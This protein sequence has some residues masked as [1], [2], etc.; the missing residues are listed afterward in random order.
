MTFLE[1]F[2]LLRHHRK[3]YE[4]RHPMWEQNRTVKAVVWI[5][6]AMV[7]IYLIFIGISLALAA[8]NIDDVTA[9]EL[10]F[11]IMPF[12]LTLD[13]LLRFTAQQTPTQMV[14][15]Y[16]LLPLPRKTCTDTFI[17]NSLL[18]TGNLIWMAMFVPYALVSVVF[19]YGVSTTLLFLLAC[20]IC[21]LLNSQWYLL[22]RTLINI[23]MW[24][25]L[26]P[27][28]V[29]AA[30]YSPLFIM[31]ADKGILAFIDFFAS[32]GDRLSNGNVLA[33][34][35]LLLMITAAVLINR[36]VQYRCI[37]NELNHKEQTR[38]HSISRMSYFNRYGTTGEFLK[39]EAKSIMRN[40]NVKKT[41]IFANALVLFISLLVALSDIYD[42]PF[43]NEFWCV[44]NF[45]IYG[46]MLL[47]KTMCYEG[48]Y[49]EC[50]MTHRN[51]IPSL[52]SAKYLFCTAM[53]LVPFVLTL[54]T[55]IAGKWTLLQVASVMVFAGG[56]INSGLL[57]L[58]IYNKQTMPLNTRF[59]GKG[60]MESNW[61]QVIAQM[62]IMFVPV[63]FIF[64]C[65]LFFTDT[66]TYIVL[67]A[68]GLP[69]LVTHRWWIRR[70]SDT[71]MHRRHDNVASLIATR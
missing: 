15:P 12:L 31:K 63:I 37:Q 4:R 16:V 5:V 18:S 26:L 21:L 52:F 41:F 66:V 40:K 49:I 14:K 56:I 27:I 71:Y 38:L 34:A 35:V 9:P 32:C 70:L 59:L 47:T 42:T 61:M 64:V 46:S 20:Y 43:M 67:M 69:G 11:G 55:V 53:L 62:L 13:F 22:V 28:A 39:L 48:N 25:W 6:V 29:Y 17:L 2:R 8:N 51:T 45:A 54:P 23:T 3:L 30:L 33:W 58:S 36:E 57:H 60:S 68:I 24:W 44:Y 1:I 7:M 65:R 19:S 50:L 10:M